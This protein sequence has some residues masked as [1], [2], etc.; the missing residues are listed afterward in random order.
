MLW[1]I[2]KIVKIVISHFEMNQ[3]LVLNNQWGVDMSLNK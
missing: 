2:G 1:Q 3:I